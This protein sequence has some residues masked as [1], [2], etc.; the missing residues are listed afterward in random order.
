MRPS[1]VDPSDSR[2]RPGKSTRREHAVRSVRKTVISVRYLAYNLAS[3]AEV[4]T[5]VRSTA[6]SVESSCK[7]RHRASNPCEWP[8]HAS[9]TQDLG[10]ALLIPGKVG[11][12]ITGTSDRREDVTDHQEAVV[13]P[14]ASPYV[15][16]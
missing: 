2:A 15:I 16:P 6:G 5:A 8:P 7:H 11:K 3:I 14:P 9:R 1:V 12:V 13:M 10:R 4:G